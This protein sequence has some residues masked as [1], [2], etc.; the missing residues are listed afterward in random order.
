MHHKPF[1]GQVY[2]TTPDLLAGLRGWGPWKGGR[3]KGEKAGEGRGDGEKWKG[4][5]EKE[6]EGRRRVFASVKIHFWVWLWYV[7][8]YFISTFSVTLKHWASGMS[9]LQACKKIP[10]QQS[11]VFLRRL[12]NRSLKYATMDNWASWSK[13]VC[14]LVL[15]GTAV[16]FFYGT[17][18]VAFT[19]LFST[20]IPQVPRFFGTVLVRC[21]HTVTNIC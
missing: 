14:V 16:P 7:W 2:S 1:G 8:Y 10:F 19:V 9:S 3:E 12:G 18:T 17:S 15:R 6:R 5:E 4:R 20:A 13:A 11:I 21:W